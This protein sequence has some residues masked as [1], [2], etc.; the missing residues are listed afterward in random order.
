MVVTLPKSN[1]DDL[2][3]F[4]YKRAP[5]KANKV[6]VNDVLAQIKPLVR[7][8]HCPIASGYPLSWSKQQR[9]LFM[10]FA[11]KQALTNTKPQEPICANYLHIRG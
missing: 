4:G 2:N 8:H 3:C 7:L 1:V 6:Q 9:R 10:Q 11:D 5:R